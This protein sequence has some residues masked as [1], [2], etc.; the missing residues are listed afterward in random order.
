MDDQIKNC[1]RILELEESAS[2]QD[3]KQAWREMAKVWHPDRFPNDP[4]L[5][6]RGQEKL[7]DVNAAYQIL[8][9]YLSDPAQHQRSGRPQPQP[10]Q[11]SPRFIVQPKDLTIHEGQDARFYA[12]VE[13][14]SDSK[15][16][17]FIWDEENGI[18]ET[19]DGQNGPLLI[20]EEPPLGN[21]SFYL[22][23]TN[24][25]GSVQ[26]RKALLTVEPKTTSTTTAKARNGINPYISE[27]AEDIFAIPCVHCQQ[28]IEFSYSRM[29]EN[30]RCPYC[31]K[32][33]FL[34]YG[35]PLVRKVMSQSAFMKPA[36]W[37]TAAIVF[38][39]IV[40]LCVFL[41]MVSYY[42]GFPPIAEQVVIWSLIGIAGAFSKKQK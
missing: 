31:A 2:T 36:K 23:A 37:K 10:T 38:A 7:K 25:A 6:E 1:Y 32:L 24:K 14:I 21:I 16:Q 29:G 41:G 27:K 12:E 11:H 42:E 30:V 20:I 15:L 9:D 3:V 39:I 22:I 18:V 35:A 40:L 28:G 34:Q 17:W 26:S 19:L 8:T 4:K 33:T 5:Q 13:D